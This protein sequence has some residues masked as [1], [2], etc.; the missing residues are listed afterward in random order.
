MAH[1][2]HII[3]ATLIDIYNLNIINFVVMFSTTIE[4]CMYYYNNIGESNRIRTGP[5]YGHS[6]YLRNHK[7]YNKM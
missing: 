7:S 5:E 4:S 2:P 6:R 3:C 1:I